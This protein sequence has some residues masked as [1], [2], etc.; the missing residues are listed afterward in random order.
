M[1]FEVSHLIGPCDLYLSAK[2]WKLKISLC[3]CTGCLCESAPSWVVIGAGSMQPGFHPRTKQEWT[4]HF[5]SSVSRRKRYQSFLKEKGGCKLENIPSRPCVSRGWYLAR[6]GEKSGFHSSED[7]S[8]DS[9][10]LANQN[11]WSSFCGSR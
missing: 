9:E 1:L 8:R 2:R 7:F 5:C 11:L 6:A 3:L 10:K 4:Q